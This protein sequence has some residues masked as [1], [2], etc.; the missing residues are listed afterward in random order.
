MQD[1]GLLLALIAATPVMPVPGQ[2]R[3]GPGLPQHVLYVTVVHGLHPQLPVVHHAVQVRTR[4]WGPLAA[5]YAVL[6]NTQASL[7]HHVVPVARGLFLVL[8]QA[9]VLHVSQAHSL[10]RSHPHAAHVQQ[11]LGPRQGLLVVFRVLLVHG[12]GLVQHHVQ[13]VLMVLGLS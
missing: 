2:L 6:G 13:I 12:Q 11:V 10:L 3:L 9:H 4:P 5:S 8:V 1:F 7:H